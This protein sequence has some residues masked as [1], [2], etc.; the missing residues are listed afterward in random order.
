MS[1][2]TYNR[3]MH[4]Q[5]VDGL[6]VETV[7]PPCPV[8]R[9]SVPKWGALGHIRCRKQEGDMPM[10]YEV[11]HEDKTTAWYEAGELRPNRKDEDYTPAERAKMLERMDAAIDQ[12]YRSAASSGCHTLIEFTGLM[13]DFLNACRA[14][15]EQG[16]QFAFASAHTGDPLP[17]VPHQFAYM[18]EKL[19][20]I[21]GPALRVAENRDA[22]VRSLFHGAFKL[23]PADP[24]HGRP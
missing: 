10:Q 13:A 11:E 14:A 4:A 19:D 7:K 3:A 21:Y 8:S 12:F 16:R 23:V 9:I 17:F 2:G 5:L 22:F 18:A 1:D 15:H 24:V 6:R 20:C